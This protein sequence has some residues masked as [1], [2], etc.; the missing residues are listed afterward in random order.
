MN[1][2][3]DGVQAQMQ[4][5]MG[6]NFKKFL[7]LLPILTLVFGGAGFGGFIS[8]FLHNQLSKIW[9]R[10]RALF[11]VSILVRGEDPNYNRVEEFLTHLV[12]QVCVRV[13]ACVCASAMHAYH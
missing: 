2:I 9:N 1:A 11:V 6:P 10:I 12:K 8:S 3:V 4:R 5:I 13:R 7:P